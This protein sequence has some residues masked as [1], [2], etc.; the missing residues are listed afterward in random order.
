MYRVF[1]QLPLLI[2]LCAGLFVAALLFS[3]CSKSKTLGEEIPSD[4]KVLPLETVLSNPETYNGQ[5]VV[6]KGIISGQCPSLCEFFYKEKGTTVTV[7]PKGYKFPK[8]ESGVPVTVY[9]EVASG[10]E[11]TILSALGIKTR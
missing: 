6:L 2:A 1:K 8:L 9:A 10:P 7:F 11:Q 5:K 3:G 4:I